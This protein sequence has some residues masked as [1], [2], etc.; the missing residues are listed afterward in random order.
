[1]VCDGHLISFEKLPFDYSHM[2][3]IEAVFELLEYFTLHET[4][5]GIKQR[6]AN[7]FCKGPHSKIFYTLRVI[8]GLCHYSAA[9]QTVS[10]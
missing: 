3:L 2:D 10:Q 4:E 6:L 5:I 7:F 1:M 9:V 8:Y